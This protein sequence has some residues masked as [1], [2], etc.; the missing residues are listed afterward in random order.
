[1][2]LFNWSEKKMKA[3]LDEIT[4]NVDV[5]DNVKD[6]EKNVTTPSPFVLIQ[7]DPYPLYIDMDNNMFISY[8]NNATFERVDSQNTFNYILEKN[9][10]YSTSIDVADIDTTTLYDA[11]GT[12]CDGYFNKTAI[13]PGVDYYFEKD[14]PSIKTTPPPAPLHISLIHNCATCGATVDIEENKPVFHCKYCGSTYVIGPAQIYS[15]Y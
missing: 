14:T 13:G 10:E 1:M 4:D 5:L 8:D 15:H 9:K 6:L 12:L 2:G 7:E 11:V 3:K